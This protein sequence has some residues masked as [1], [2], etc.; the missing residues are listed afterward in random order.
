MII[1]YNIINDNLNDTEVYNF[2]NEDDIRNIEY[3]KKKK[4]LDGIVLNMVQILS[5]TSVIE[6][7]VKT[8]IYLNVKNVVYS[9]D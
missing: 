3:V 2:I 4:K 8:N 6:A 9:L 5:N 7:I 1:I